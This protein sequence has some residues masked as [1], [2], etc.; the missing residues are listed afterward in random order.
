MIMHARYENPPKKHSSDVL[1]NMWRKGQ[2]YVITLEE[3]TVRTSSDYQ[4]KNETL[5]RG[6]NEDDWQT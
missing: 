1:K 6:S 5:S 4:I 3:Y 2:Y